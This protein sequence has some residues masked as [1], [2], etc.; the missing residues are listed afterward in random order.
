MSLQEL[1]LRHFDAAG[2][3]YEQQETP[4]WPVRVRIVKRIVDI[5]FALVALPTLA[6]TMIALLVL[7]P[8]FNPGP[9]FFRQERMGQGGVPFRVWKFRTMAPCDTSKR[10]HDDPL[11]EHRISRLGAILRKT[12]IDELPNFINVLR[13]EMSLIGPRPDMVEHAIA[14]S[15]TI[16]RYRERFR[17]KP[18]ITGLAQIRYGYADHERAVRRKAQNDFIYIDR[19][20]LGLDLHIILRTIAVMAT[21][22]GAK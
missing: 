10:G 4:P 12:R 11:E 18:G 21:G 7:N 2:S 5:H 20:S 6:V 8:F 9:L 15:A 19:Y 16:P 1:D 13:G 14:Y 3:S 17:V 22:F